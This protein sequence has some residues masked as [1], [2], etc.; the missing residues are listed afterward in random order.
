MDINIR[1]SKVKP[2]L[3]WKASFNDGSSLSQFNENL[4]TKFKE[5]QDKF[6]QLISFELNHI[7]KS[8]QVKVDLQKGLI[9]INSIS[10]TPPELLNRVRDNIRIIYFRRNQVD[11]DERGEIIEHRLYHFV[12]YQYN[13]KIG[14]NHKVILVIDQ[15]G[16]IVIGA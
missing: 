1:K 3:V 7:S 6:D 16:N 8:F 11:T 15:E 4:E 2:N 10:Y 9:S 13:D 12:G 14:V 5:V